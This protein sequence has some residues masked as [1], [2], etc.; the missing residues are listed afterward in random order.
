MD[1]SG[2]A[3]PPSSS[4]YTSESN[5]ATSNLAEQRAAQNHPRGKPT[6]ERLPTSQ[7]SGQEPTAAPLGHGVRGVP[8]GKERFGKTEEQVGRHN[9]L[10]GDQ[11]RTLNEGDISDAVDRKPGATG[12]QPD[13]ASDLDRKK[14]EQASKRERIKEQKERGQL[15]GFSDARATQQEGINEA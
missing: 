3:Q 12:S 1:P 11:L 6:D 5:P 13:F 9:E 10:E 15:S 4:A 2:P 14:A 7:A 8:A